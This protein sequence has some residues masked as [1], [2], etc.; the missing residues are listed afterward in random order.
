MSYSYIFLVHSYSNS[1][2]KRDSLSI[3]KKIK[4]R[5]VF[6]ITSNIVLPYIRYLYS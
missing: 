4:W 5:A 1:N 6:N 2:N 3:Y